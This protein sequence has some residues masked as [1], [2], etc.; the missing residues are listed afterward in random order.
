VIT[1]VGHIHDAGIGHTYL[2][3]I[4]ASTGVEIWRRQYFSRHDHDD[5]TDVVQNPGDYRFMVV[6]HAEDLLGSGTLMWV[7]NTNDNN[8]IL[9]NGATYSVPA[10]YRSLFA[11]DVCL[12]PD[13][14]S[15]T[16]TGF[17]TSDTPAG[18]SETKTFIMK[19]PF[20]PAALPVFS[21]YFTASDPQPFLLSDEAIETIGGPNPGY[22]LGTEAKLP[23]AGPFDYDVH[24]LQLDVNGLHKFTDDCPVVRFP[25]RPQEEGKS[26]NLRRE[27]TKSAW[28]NLIVQVEQQ[29]FLQDP[30]IEIIGQP[31]IGSNSKE[32]LQPMEAR[33][34]PNP[35]VAGTDVNIEFD[36]DQPAEVEIQLF[37]VTGRICGQW[38]EARDKGDQFMQ[39]QLPASANEKMYL[40]KIVFPDGRFQVLRLLVN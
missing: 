2:S 18:I 9:A 15:G 11:R 25:P 19:L 31:L 5:G 7:F 40:V 13:V 37:D 22:V 28:H 10:P 24:A 6:G 38:R 17:I 32:P 4:K 21:H 29:E 36:L 8:G 3:C 23:G 26:A 14:K 39:I 1:I 16:I 30:C 33:L 27:Q 20:A 12:S 34:Y 35:V